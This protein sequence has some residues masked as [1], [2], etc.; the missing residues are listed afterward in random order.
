MDTSV[1][2]LSTALAV[3]VGHSSHPSQ[4]HLLVDS[5]LGIGAGVLVVV[6]Y[7]LVLRWHGSR[8]EDGDRGRG[9]REMTDRGSSP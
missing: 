4:Y 6:G 3:V 1:L 2:G 9:D 5:A 7:L 8:D